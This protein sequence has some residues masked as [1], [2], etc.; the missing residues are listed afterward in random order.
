MHDTSPGCARTYQLIDRTVPLAARLVAL[1]RMW[2]LR[3]TVRDVMSLI[4]DLR[5]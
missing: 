4:Q 5:G 1:A 2:L 3:S